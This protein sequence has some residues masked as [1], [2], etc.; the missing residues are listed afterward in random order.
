MIFPDFVATNECVLF[1]LPCALEYKLIG[2]YII[3]T[4]VEVR[5]FPTS[6]P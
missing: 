3:P 4:F 2:F 1:F 6:V 5:A